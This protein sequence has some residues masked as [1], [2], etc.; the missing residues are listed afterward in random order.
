M[1]ETFPAELSCSPE[2]HM[3]SDPE[4]V[5]SLPADYFRNSRS[6]AARASSGVA[7]AFDPVRSNDCAGAKKVHSLRFFL[8]GIRA[9]IG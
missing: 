4:G 7:V 1:Q 2:G 5:R 9:G 6:N 8:E 3:G